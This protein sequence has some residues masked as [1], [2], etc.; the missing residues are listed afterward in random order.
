M[1]DAARKQK[2]EMLEQDFNLILRVTMQI[3]DGVL[4]Q[5]AANDS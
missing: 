1:R 3:T 4:G 5:F 2:K